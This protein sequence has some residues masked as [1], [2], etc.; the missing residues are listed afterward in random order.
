[1]GIVGGRL[2]RGMD[3]DPVDC[4]IEKAVLHFPAAKYLSLFI[5]AHLAFTCLSLL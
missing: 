1:M 4:V 3:I 2:K 5:H